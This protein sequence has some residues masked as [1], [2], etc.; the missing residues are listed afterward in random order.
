MARNEQFRPEDEPFRTN[1]QL[2]LQPDEVNGPIWF[3]NPTRATFIY[4]GT[5]EAVST[6]EGLHDVEDTHLQAQDSQR[7]ESH[8]CIEYNWTS[9]DNRKGRH[10]VIL[11]E[12]YDG[13]CPF[14]APPPTNTPASTP[15]TKRTFK[16]PQNHP[17]FLTART[18]AEPGRFAP[19]LSRCMSGLE[20]IAE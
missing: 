10:A 9:R 4:T 19:S 12:S 5:Y 8:S 17:L 7:V 2:Q 20:R 18:T 11:R 14:Q 16:I 1:E 3:M 6:A 13:E 15:S